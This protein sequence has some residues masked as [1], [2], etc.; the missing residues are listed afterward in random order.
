MAHA[1]RSA[2]RPFP[3]ARASCAGRAPLA[4][5]LAL[6]TDGADVADGMGGASDEAGGP[7]DGLR[8]WNKSTDH[9]M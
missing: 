1:G 2:P 8:A 6:S 9:W 5:L 3:A 4:V 7:P